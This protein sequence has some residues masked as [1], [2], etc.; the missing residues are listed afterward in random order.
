MCLACARG[1]FTTA[2]VRGWVRWGRILKMQMP[3]AHTWMLRCCYVSG[4]GLGGV[5]WGGAGSCALRAHVDASLL[6][7][8]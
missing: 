8:Q 6:L 7:R 2:V 5:G 3:C 4:L 1:C